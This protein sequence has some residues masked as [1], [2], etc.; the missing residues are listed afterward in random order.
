MNNKSIS[1]AYIC[2]HQMPYLK[3]LITLFNL[4]ISKPDFQNILY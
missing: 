2:P 4:G 1:T 3:T